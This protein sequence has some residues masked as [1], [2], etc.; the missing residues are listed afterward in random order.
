MGCPDIHAA[1]SRASSLSFPVSVGESCITGPDG[2]IFEL[3]SAEEWSVAG[4]CLSVE[5]GMA[6]DVRRF[7]EKVLGARCAGDS[8]TFGV[9]SCQKNI[10]L[11][12]SYE[13]LV[14]ISI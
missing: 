14:C 1:Q 4:V 6:Q 5:E 2:Y 11:G 13:P 12:Q 10:F 9:R 3:V 7:Y 8:V